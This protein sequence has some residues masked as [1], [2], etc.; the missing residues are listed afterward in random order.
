[1]ECWSAAARWE[2]FHLRSLLE[3]VD[4]LPGARWEGFHFHC[5]DD[6]YESL[7]L[8][9]LLMERVSLSTA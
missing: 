2:G 7:T 4:P 9:E 6:Y 3:I 5:A 8:G 1:V